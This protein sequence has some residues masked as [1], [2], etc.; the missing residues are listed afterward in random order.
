MP[1]LEQMVKTKILHGSVIARS[2]EG[3]Y[4]FVVRTGDVE[5]VLSIQRGG[6]RVF[7]KLD[8]LVAYVRSL[9]IQWM[10]IDLGGVGPRA[11]TG[12]RRRGSDTGFAVSK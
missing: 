4:L 1:L 8:A 5:Q 11:D 2:I 9:N 3:G 10:S 7:K 6:P 12:E